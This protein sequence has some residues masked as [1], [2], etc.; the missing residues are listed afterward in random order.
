MI[1]GIILAFLPYIE[2]GFSPRVQWHE[3]AGGYIHFILISRCCPNI[4]LT[5]LDGAFK[6]YFGV[7]ISL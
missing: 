5:G 4:F 3:I 7:L 1:Q 6:V 2:Y